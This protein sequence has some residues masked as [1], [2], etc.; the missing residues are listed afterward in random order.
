M[1]G[2]QIDR[3]VKNISDAGAKKT[4]AV[5]PFEAADPRTARRQVTQREGLPP[6]FG[7]GHIAIALVTGGLIHLATT[8]AVPHLATNSA[9]SYLQHALPANRM[10]VM[11]TQIAGRQILP[12][13]PTDY[14]YAMCRFDVRSDPVVI[15]ARLGGIGWSLTVYT[16]QGDN[17]DAIP[18]V[19][20]GPTDVAL[21][22]VPPT[23][24]MLNM[25]PG[26]RR[27]AL[28][29]NQLTVPTREGLVVVRAPITGEAMIGALSRELQ[30]TTACEPTSLGV[31]LR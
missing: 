31:P 10:V 21:M 29:L 13:L 17:I 14:L 2:T 6:I 8:F 16:P 24:Q 20:K 4:S 19:A 1:I 27:D 5:K 9:Y 18:G 26:A 22:M 15:R 11:P 3:L 23:E 7:L 28:R 30:Q 12:E 25:L